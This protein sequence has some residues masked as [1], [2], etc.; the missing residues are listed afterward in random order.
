M[1]SHLLFSSS[2]RDHLAC[3]SLRCGADL[4]PPYVDTIDLQGP[5]SPS[6]K[7]HSHSRHQVNDSTAPHQANT[8]RE[9]AHQAAEDE[10]RSPRLSWA[11]GHDPQA[12]DDLANSVQRRM[13]DDDEQQQQQAAANAQN[14]SS[15]ASSSD[16][17]EDDDL[18]DD[19]MDRISS[20]PSIDDG[21]YPRASLPRPARRSWPRRI[22]SL[23]HLREH[24]T[25]TKLSSTED[26][27]SPYLDAPEHMPL[28]CTETDGRHLLL[29]QQREHGEFD[30]CDYVHDTNEDD[31]VHEG[32]YDDDGIWGEARRRETRCESGLAGFH[33][34]AEQE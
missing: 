28:H 1:L 32:E 10:S 3:G 17:G 19:M 18:D 30:D 34:S 7:D 33:G 8:L 29:R 27:S 15:G 4:S 9:V 21:A 5:N 24:Y 16:E 25:A 26:L 23:Q 13:Q 2:F 11:D 14:G 20:S 22:S 31:E 12:Q 6:A